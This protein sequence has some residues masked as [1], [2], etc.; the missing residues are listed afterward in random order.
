V[1]DNYKRKDNTISWLKNRRII[2]YPS[3]DLPHKNNENTVKAFEQFNQVL[4]NQFTL[5]ISSNYSEKSKLKLGSLSPN[6]EFTGPI[7]D[8]AFLE[9]LK[10]CEMVLFTSYV[11]GLGLPILEAVKEKK[12]VVCSTIDAHLEIS[13]TAFYY[14]NPNDISSIFNSMM[15]SIQLYDWAE[16]SSQYS[17]INR[18]Y[19]WTNTSKL[20]IENL[21]LESKIKHIKK[22]IISIFVDPIRSTDE[23]LGL[24]SII[25]KVA[26][27]YT[28]NL[29]ITG[30]IKS[31]PF[32]LP[33]LFQAIDVKDY[34]PKTIKNVH[35]IT[36]NNNSYSFA[37]S[38][39]YPGSIFLINSS[40]ENLTQQLIDDG[41]I[42]QNA[43]DAKS[44]SET[45]IGE[46]KSNNS[47]IYSNCKVSST[48]IEYIDNVDSIITRRL[49]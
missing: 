47:I 38:I 17:K 2:F 46:I 24:S 4:G 25:C 15:E 33:S 8:A 31:S 22:E 20:F 18:R 37:L 34:N 32:Y 19:S 30:A 3:A 35:F 10:K 49:I 1:Q 28:I 13:D 11:E 48:Q 6:I 45:L 12:A 39:L 40:I 36:D 14:C 5:V 23:M 43:S 9:L 21:P 16:K 29:V 7:D 26:T 27:E 44:I 41:Y 42:S